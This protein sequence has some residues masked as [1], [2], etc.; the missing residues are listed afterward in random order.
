MLPLILS[1]NQSWKFFRGVPP[2][3][4]ANDPA[5]AYDVG[6][7]MPFDTWFCDSEWEVVHLPH[8]VRVE[9][10][11]CSGGYNYE[12]ECW[13]RKKFTVREEWTDCEMFFEFDGIMQRVDAWLDGKP[14]GYARGGFL[15]V[16]FDVSGISAGDHL[17]VLR[18]DN[19][20]VADVPP[21]KPQGALDFCYFGGIYRNARFVIKNKVRF[22][23]AVHEGRPAAG[24]LFI[25]TFPEEGKA[26]VR[27]RAS[28]LNHERADTEIGL[29]LLLNGEK[30]YE[31]ACS[32]AA[33]GERDIDCSFNV[34]KPKLWSPSRP[35]LYT[36]TA[37]LSR[38]GELID[39][40]T[41]RFGIRKVEFRADGFYLNGEKLYLN[42][43]NRHQEYP[44][45]G[46]ALPDAL[47]RRDVRTLREAGVVCI[48]TAHY[49]PDEVFMN[50][51]DELG[52]LCVIPTPGWQVHPADVLFDERSYE[53][54]R[55]LIRL[56]RN[57]ASALMWE[58]I[59][60]ETDFPLYF[61]ETQLKIVKEE[62]GDT[63]AFASCDSCS[64]GAEKFPVNYR[65]GEVNGEKPLFIREYG[66]FYMEQYGPMGTMRRVRRGEHTGYYPGGER[67]M[68]RSARERL[69][70]YERWLKNPR[71]SG[72]ALWCGFDN[73][74]GYE[75]NEGAWGMLDFL[76]LPKFFYHALSAQQS[77]EEAGV[78]CFI[79]NF[80]TENSPTDVTVYSNAEAV[81]LSLNG[82]LVAQKEVEK[83]D[84]VNHPVVFENLSF[85]KG[86]LRAE[87]LVNNAV[88]AVHEARTP[89]APYAVR[90][91]P[92]FAGEMSWRAN[93][94]DL[95]LVHAQIVDKNGTIVPSA[96]PNITF[97]VEGDAEIVGK[98]ESWV[99]ADVARAEAGITGVLLRAGLVGGRVRLFAESE[100]LRSAEIVLLTEQDDTA[101][102]TGEKY[103]NPEKLPE[104]SCDLKEFFYARESIKD[105]QAHH[106]DIGALKNATASSSAEGFGAE[107]ANQKEISRPWL[108]QDASLP[109]WWCCDLAE[110]FFVNG[111][112]ISW[113]KDWLWYDYR[114]E[115]SLDGEGWECHF[116]GSASGQ[117]RLPDRFATTAKARF[118]RIVI[119]SISGKDP[120]GIYHVEIFGKKP[121]KK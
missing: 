103:K 33:M 107:G 19:S 25:R 43:S 39:E 119:E 47:Q 113:E 3:G 49:P 68:L 78:K 41:E 100:G 14:L 13:Y 58:P 7:T 104:Y 101:Y 77:V 35:T 52:I 10:L 31:T 91:I 96:E 75:L 70:L 17:L 23:S 71:V 117:T 120:A 86:V 53:N 51:C 69:E 76:R 46:F 97:R 89:E 57:H 61:A 93:G 56:H 27:V 88:A 74:R 24:G 94:T 83:T 80:W 42:G 79:A 66:D 26:E 81:R 29:D 45:V 73:N 50:A 121:V 82:R 114:V 102:L 32:V 1:A 106:W 64:R 87:A 99:K 98:R 110:E 116:R 105:G 36:L 6:M 109:Q 12:G 63:A 67:A 4:R 22:S 72:A 16:R 108:A 34:E 5:N 44:Y 28:V 30:V 84:G 38:R 59:L 2:K 48:R 60:N 115:T 111:V 65:Y 62:C 90:L 112:A 37:R 95:L 54:T 118:V 85:E 92:H 11:L 8:T 18:V 21:G 20:A 15:P 9:R 40:R 55:R